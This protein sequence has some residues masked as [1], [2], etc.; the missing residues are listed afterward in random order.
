MWDK[1]AKVC[2]TNLLLPGTNTVLTSVQ[3]P[4]SNLDY[5]HSLGLG[6]IV[7]IIDGPDNRKYK[8]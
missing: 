4:Q 1:E 3:L 2:D 5:P 7:G 8:Y 6:K